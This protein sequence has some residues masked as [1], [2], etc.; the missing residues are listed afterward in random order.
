MCLHLCVPQGELLL[1]V[2][3]A[4]GQNT[5]GEFRESTP[6]LWGAGMKV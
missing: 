1:P 4:E 5:S 6:Y 2:Y 3:V